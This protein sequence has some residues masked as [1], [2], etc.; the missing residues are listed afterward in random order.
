MNEI[1]DGDIVLVDGNGLHGEA[2]VVCHPPEG[3]GYA[4]MGFIAIK[5]NYWPS[6]TYWVEEKNCHKVQ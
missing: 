1:Q 5:Q 4:N 3:S 6:K 2:T